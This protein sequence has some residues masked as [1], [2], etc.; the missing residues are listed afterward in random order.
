MRAFPTAHPHPRSYGQISITLF[1]W[2]FGCNWQTI[3]YQGCL[4]IFVFERIYFSFFPHFFLLSFFFLSFFP[5]WPDRGIIV[6]LLIVDNVYIV[7]LMPA[8]PWTLMW[9]QSAPNWE[10]LLL[11]L[12]FLF[13]TAKTIQFK[14]ESSEPANT[15]YLV[16]RHALCLDAKHILN[17]CGCD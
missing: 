15:V 17:T 16:K 4:H 3:L 14:P 11:F 1:N 8:A 10:K 13:R 2:V 6:V 12:Q 7:G 5:S 9:S